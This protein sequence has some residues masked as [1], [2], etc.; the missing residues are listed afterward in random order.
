LAVLALAGSVAALT[1]S[2]PFGSTPRR[3][4]LHAALP[5][6]PSPRG[7]GAQRVEPGPVAP[8]PSPPPHPAPPPPTAS[9][10]L[11]VAKPSG[12]RPTPSTQAKST[13]TTRP[14]ITGRWLRRTNVVDRARRG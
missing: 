9:L 7:P 6:A 1:G 4:S 14:G 12:G 5:S 13:A 10:G 11:A 2:L 3:P 8:A